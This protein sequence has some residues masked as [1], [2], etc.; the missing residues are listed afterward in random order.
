M[1]ISYELDRS[2]AALRSASLDQ[3]GYQNEHQQVCAKAGEACPACLGNDRADRPG[4]A[5]FFCRRC[6]KLRADRCTHGNGGQKPRRRMKD[7]SDPHSSFGF[8][9]SIFCT[10]LRSDMSSVRLSPMPLRSSSS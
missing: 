3:G 4:A 1:A 9:H 2:A 10:I 7:A 6:R 8:H 5:F